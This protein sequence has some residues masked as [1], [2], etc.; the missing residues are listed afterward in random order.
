MELNPG[1]PLRL[2]DTEIA[3][4]LGVAALLGLL[5]GLDRELRRSPAGLRTHG[6][7]CLS[8]AAMTASVIVLYNQFDGP[9]SRMDPLRIVQGAGAFFG[10]VAAGLVFVRKGDVRNLTTAVHL[11]LAAVIGIACGAGQWPLVAVAVLLAITMMTVIGIA[12]KR[13]L[14]PRL[15]DSEDEIR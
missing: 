9:Q 8:A 3:L 2:I 11:W 7:V 10:I 6:L 4:R 12:E 5:L 13:W 14:E 1:F 15:D